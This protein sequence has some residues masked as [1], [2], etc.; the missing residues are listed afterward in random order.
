MKLSRTNCLKI[1]YL[2]PSIAAT[3]KDFLPQLL[4]LSLHSYHNRES[5]ISSACAILWRLLKAGA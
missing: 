2:A 3:L 4:R 1:N 5:V